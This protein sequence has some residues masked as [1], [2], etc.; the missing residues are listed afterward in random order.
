MAHE[1][2]TS[3]AGLCEDGEGGMQSVA[4]DDRLRGLDRRRPSRHWQ[5]PLGGNGRSV[6]CRGSRARAS[7]RPARPVAA[8]VAGDSLKGAYEAPIDD[9]ESRQFRT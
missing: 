8:A 1:A 6:A 9:A 4:V 5:R 3:T 2:G 7:D